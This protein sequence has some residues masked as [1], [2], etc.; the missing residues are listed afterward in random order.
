[1]V[2]GEDRLSTI[3][4]ARSAEELAAAAAAKNDSPIDQISDLPSFH[5]ITTESEPKA[6]ENAERSVEDDSV[7][8]VTDI[9]EKIGIQNQIT[10]D[11]QEIVPSH[12]YCVVDEASIAASVSESRNVKAY[13]R[14]E[15]GR[16]VT[17]TRKEIGSPA[18]SDMEGPLEGTEIV[19]VSEPKDGPAPLPQPP[20]SNRYPQYYR[21]IFLLNS[22][23][24][25]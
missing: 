4:E 24:F 3:E 20:D 10:S 15:I 2:S 13:E 25:F 21:E 7:T 11:T 1:M 8:L 16:L 18:D 9:A 14:L 12:S 19:S 23:I 5:T 22:R 6:Q 17:R